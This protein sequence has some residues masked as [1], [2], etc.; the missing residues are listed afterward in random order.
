L[1]FSDHILAFSGSAAL[2]STGLLSDK[3]LGCFFR[4]YFWQAFSGSAA[5]KLLVP[6]LSNQTKTGL[7]SD[8]IL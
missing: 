3:E 7:F 4:S 2:K 5:L 8:H 1:F 6:A